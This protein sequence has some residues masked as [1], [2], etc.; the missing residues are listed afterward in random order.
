MSKQ[1]NKEYQRLLKRIDTD[2]EQSHENQ[3]ESYD[4]RR[5]CFVSGAQWDGEVG[6]QFE[7]RP[8][9]EFNKIQLSIIRVYNEWAKN[10]FTVEFRPK[11]MI[12]D[13]DTADNLQQLFRADE[14]DSNA[15]EAYSTAFFEGI[16][17]GI[18]AIQVVAEYEDEYS[19]EDDLQR[20]RIKPI[21]EADTTVYWD[22]NAKRYDKAD[23]SHVTLVTSM[24]SAD[25]EAKYNKE[26]LSFDDLQGYR[27][28][29]RDGDNIRVAEHYELT[30]TKVDAVRLVHE[31]AEPVT[32]YDDADD[33]EE[34]L[35]E[36]TAQG[37][38]VELTKTIK[39]RVVK[40]YVLDGSGLI[41]K[42]EVIAGNYLPIVP[43]YGKRM[44]IGGREVTQGHVRLSK[45]AQI[46]YNVKMSGLIDLASRPQ[47]ELPIFTPA[48]IKGHEYI[49][50]TKE[51]ERK[52]YL[53]I[54]PTKDAQ[55]NVIGVGPQSYT[56]PPVIP[57]AMGALIEKAGV[58][59]AELTGNQ[60]NGE[61]LV[62]N[63]ST[64]AVEMVQDK[65]DAQA[66]IYLD[67]FAKT[68]AH[69]GRVWLSIAKVIYDEEERP[70]AGV[71]HDDQDTEIIINK[72][73]IKDGQ[74]AYEN[75]IQ[76]GTYKV[77]VDVG[78]AFTTQRDKTIKRLIS[79]LPTMQD[80]QQ[81]AA[82]THTI[83]SNTDSEGM[84]DLAQWSRKQLINMGVVK[85]NEKEQQEMAAA[86]QA[87]ANQ[88]PSVQDK[89]LEA[90]ASKALADAEHKK[91]ETQK[92]LA[93]VDETRADTAKT[94]YEMQQEQVQT[95]QMMQE[96]MVILQAMQQSQGQAEQAI[97]DEV[98]PPPAQPQMPNIPG[99]P[100]LP[101]GVDP[102]MLEQMQDM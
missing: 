101:D 51:V 58:D 31:H 4:D 67:N 77:T 59:I 15:E 75:D 46:A 60:A 43:F 33:F 88:P 34:Q 44:Y 12:A 81:Q 28:D 62:S 83:L 9:F 13:Q 86:E 48:Q 92:T 64:Q 54:N 72:P 26:P 24:S 36:L 91:A 11:N 76:G 18:G 5:F 17:G 69:V 57:Q 1:K 41:K 29:W 97:K 19:I 32:L 73:T 93:E 90:E 74:L 55:G 8:K 23:A 66:Y 3:K 89:Y 61:Q 37:Y 49:W 99:M 30:E 63:V 65:V 45:D 94:L 100:Q 42:P 71:S 47:D 79:M 2:Y 96:M 21:F 98:T 7:G 95:Q 40:C 84:R 70:M 14:R 102:A 53:T 22:A 82:L 80:P 27:F 87:A 10:R 56:K 85:P 52:P 68:M 39:K 78:E 35:D 20:I 6:K 38:I 16:S 25:F 50:A